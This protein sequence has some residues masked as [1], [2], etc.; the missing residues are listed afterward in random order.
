MAYKLL[1]AAQHRWR[2]VNAPE[3]VALVRAG[4]TF[5]DGRLQERKETPTTNTDAGSVA[6]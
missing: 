5:N 2:R 3:L 6:A 4:A 1:D